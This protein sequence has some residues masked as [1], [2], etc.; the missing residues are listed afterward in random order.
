MSKFCSHCG[1]ELLDEAVI[2][3]GCGC[4]VGTSSNAAPTEKNI[5]NELSNKVKTNG[6]IWLCIGGVQVFVGLYVYWLVLIVAVINIILG[7]TDI[8][9]S[10]KILTD[11]NGIVKRYEPIVGPIITLAYNLIFG[12][13]IGV[14]GSIYYLVAIR[15]FVVTHKNEFLDLEQNPQ[16]L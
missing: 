4:K 5:V 11:Q 2:C 10:S 14:I 1:K 12:G 16:S 6:I 13:I 9:Y 3:P 7:I 15:S 8:R